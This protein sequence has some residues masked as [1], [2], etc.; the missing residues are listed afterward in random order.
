MDVTGWDTVIFTCRQPREIYRRVLACIA[1][2][3]PEALVD[4]TV[5]GRL[6][7]GTPPVPLRGVS[8]ERLPAEEGDAFFYRDAAMIRHTDEFAF[9]PMA[10]GDGPFM[11]ASRVRPNVVFR[12]DRLEELRPIDWPEFPKMEPYSAWVC[13]PSLY[14]ITVVTP[15]DPEEHAFSVWACEIVRRACG[16]PA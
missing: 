16:E 11:V 7:S 15:G 8:S 9:A 13:S 12:V 2:R 4:I 3:W 6:G 5:D 1:Q 14:E 10:D